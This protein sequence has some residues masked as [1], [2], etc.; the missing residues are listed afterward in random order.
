[1]D[2]NCPNHYIFGCFP[3]QIIAFVVIDCSY[4]RLSYV[5][6]RGLKVRL[7]CSTQCQWCYIIC[8]KFMLPQTKILE[9]GT[10]ARACLFDAIFE[11]SSPKSSTHTLEQNFEIAR[12]FFCSVIQNL[13][14]G[15]IKPVVRKKVNTEMLFPTWQ[16]CNDWMPR[17]AP[18]RCNHRLKEVHIPN[19]RTRVWS[20][21]NE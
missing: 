12:P 19:V 14:L 17:H 20:R 18:M 8:N 2:S 6:T 3:T 21:R 13:R 7:F 10:K 15:G 1:M 9:D 5:F 16:R 4:L 11:A